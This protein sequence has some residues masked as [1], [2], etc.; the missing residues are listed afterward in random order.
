MT[1]SHAAD[2]ALA[3]PGAAD[4]AG[5]AAAAAELVARFRRQWPLRAG[6][7]IVTLFGDCIMP[8]GGAIALGSLITLAAPFGLNER[9][10]RTATA[11]LAK[12]GWL[13]GRRSGKLSEYHLSA[14]GRER[15]AEA[16]K[17]IYDAP[18]ADWPG[19]WTVVVLPAMR[20]AE[21]KALSD[22]LIWR[23]FGALSNNVFAHPQLESRAFTLPRRTGGPLSQVIVFDASLADDDSPQRLVSMGWNLEDLARRYQLFV[24]RF[25]PVLTALQGTRSLDHQAGFIVRTLLIHE[26]RR[27]HLRDPMLPPRLLPADWPGAKAAVLCRDIYARIFTASEM[28]LSRVAAR[29]EGPLPPPDDSVR[30]RFG[31][32]NRD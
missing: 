20:A 15:F 22:E 21:R 7:L 27:L 14:D 23:G 30:R 13:E 31:G 32:I 6:S 12:D 10:V 8:R 16:T 3:R 29:L 25:E 17:R 1:D 4:A 24:K 28:H 9:L 5:P 26:Y 19:R 11:R 2:T 18:D